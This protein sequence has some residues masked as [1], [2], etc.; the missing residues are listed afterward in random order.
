MKRTVLW[1]MHVFVMIKQQ[2]WG[3]LC[4]SESAAY[5]FHEASLVSHSAPLLLFRLLH[6]NCTNSLV[7]L[8]SQCK[9]CLLLITVVTGHSPASRWD[10]IKK[11]KKRKKGKD[12]WSIR[13]LMAVLPGGLQQSANKAGAGRCWIWA[14]F[15]RTG[16][17]SDYNIQ[18]TDWLWQIM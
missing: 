18:F 9:I 6:Y 12:G 8:R 4:S 3:R 11:K 16:C 17:S 1:F 5:F 10:L 2:T 15:V 7:R 14:R 13:G